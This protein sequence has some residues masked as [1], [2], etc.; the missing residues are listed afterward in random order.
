MHIA[1]KPR[2]NNTSTFE[3]SPFLP[4]LNDTQ[5]KLDTSN[6]PHRRDPVRIIIR[7]LLSFLAT[8]APAI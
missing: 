1:L 7:V 6:T 4:Q 8:N 3:A 2:H 5:Q